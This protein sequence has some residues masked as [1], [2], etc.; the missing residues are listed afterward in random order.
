MKQALQPLLEVRELS[1]GYGKKTVVRD[2]SFSLS[3]GALCGLVG[4]NG[5]GKSTLIKALCGLVRQNGA[6]LVDGRETATLTVRQRACRIAYFAQ[7]A[8]VYAPLPAV[9]VVLMGA[10]PRLGVLERPSCA[11]RERALAL[12]RHVGIDPQSSILEMSEGERQ[13]TLLARTMLQDAQLLLLDEADSALDFQNRSRTLSLLREYL[14]KADRA[15]ILCTHDVNF[16]L[17][18]CSRLLLLKDGVLVDDLILAQTED[19][20]LEHSL[21]QL[22]GAVELLRCGSARIMIPKEEQAG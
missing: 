6:V 12:L 15:A 9:E 5:S 16:A 2:C 18:Y 21:R 13:L 10:N 22:Y 20:A 19:A 1:A 11:Q 7:R 14:H 8:A 3:S 4:A 17:R